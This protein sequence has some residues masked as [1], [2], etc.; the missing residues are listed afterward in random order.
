HL[1]VEFVQRDRSRSNVMQSV[2]RINHIPS[3]LI[4]ELIDHVDQT[5]ALPR[6]QVLQI[7]SVYR[8]PGQLEND[9]VRQLDGIRELPHRLQPVYVHQLQ[10][11]RKQINFI[12][13]CRSDILRLPWRPVQELLKLILCEGSNG[14]QVLPKPTPTQREPLQCLLHILLAHE[15]GPDEQ[16]S[17]SQSRANGPLPFRTRGSPSKTPKFLELLSLFA[18]F[19]VAVKVTL[20]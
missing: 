8:H 5:V 15:L 16:I 3:A 14:N 11:Q 18:G 17:Q 4:C 12:Q 10:Q 1:L 20:Q 7:Q 13:A 9:V 2:H 19:I 6:A